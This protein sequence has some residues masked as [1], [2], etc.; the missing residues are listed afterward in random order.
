MN[1]DPRPADVDGDA[2]P[3]PS[4]PLRRVVLEVEAHV[5]SAGWDQ[6][7][8]L[9]ALVRTADLVAAEPA[10]ADQL[11]VSLRDDPDGYT[12]I[13]QEELPADQPLED[14]LDDLEWP[15]AVHGCAV[16]LERIMLPPEAEADL[17]DNP[18]ELVQ[19]VAEHPQRREVR[20]VAA[21]SRD[22]DRHSA[23]RSRPVL[24]DGA[25]SDGHSSDGEQV[26]SELLEGPDLVPG[27]T[28]AL[29]RTLEPSA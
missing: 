18:V 3:L 22:G 16:V 20:L 14:V 28:D 21:V 23:V 7:P 5:S 12:T 29:R 8:R 2:E 15:D 24:V 27:L 25:A 9:Y 11:A 13:E 10:L 17:P 4:T 26:A 19:A 1:D 6:P